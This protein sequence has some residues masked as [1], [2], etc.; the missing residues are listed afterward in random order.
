MPMQKAVFATKLHQGLSDEIVKYNVQGDICMFAKRFCI[1]SIVRRLFTFKGN[2][3][4]SND[5][6]LTDRI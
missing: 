5:E 4:L 3:K 6:S 2:W 1:A